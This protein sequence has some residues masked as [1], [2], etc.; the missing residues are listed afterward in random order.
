[1]SA[2]KVAQLLALVHEGRVIATKNTLENAPLDGFARRKLIKPKQDSRMCLPKKL[3]DLDDIGGAT[4]YVVVRVV[5]VDDGK[6]PRVLL[7]N[8]ALQLVVVTRW[9]HDD[10]RPLNIERITLAR[11]V[12]VEE[13]HQEISI[14]KRGV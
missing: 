11:A 2:V 10:T 14:V 7:C 5:G 6:P 1:M 13:S 3:E 12:E 4:R 9:I 8:G